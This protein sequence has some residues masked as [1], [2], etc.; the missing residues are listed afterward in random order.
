MRLVLLRH[1][2]TIWNAEHRFQGQSDIPLDETGEAQAE[3][4]AR[5]LAALSPDL[6][7]SSDLVRAMSTAAP[8][9]ALTGLTVTLDKGLRERFGGAWEGL[10]DTEID[11]RYPRERATW[12][13]PGGELTM[14][15]AD[16]VHA[17]LRRV[18]DTLDQ[19]GGDLAVVVSHG[20]ALRLGMER[21]LGLPD[22]HFGV[23]GPLSNC[24]WSVLAQRGPRWRILEHNAGTLPEPVLGDDR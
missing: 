10:T 19:N 20:A 16:R 9:A 7:V 8:L 1:G 22:E 15:V 18:A 11:E 12:D 4:S 17:A 5:L 14:A 6:I 24:S 13:P 2:Q 23:L 21:M 3:R